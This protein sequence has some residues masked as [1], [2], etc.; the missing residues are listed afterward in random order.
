MSELAQFAWFDSTC[1]FHSGTSSSKLL[2]SLHVPQS[3]FSVSQQ[4]PKSCFHVCRMFL[5]WLII[6]ALALDFLCSVC[7][8]IMKQSP[9]EVDSFSA[10]QITEGKNTGRSISNNIFEKLTAQKN[11]VSSSLTSRT[12]LSTWAL[13][14]F[15]TYY[16]LWLDQVGNCPFFA[17]CYLLINCFNL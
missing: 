17:G 6:S 1:I 5:V 14:S 12:I 8:H 2:L 7:N 9:W 4:A 11:A 15:E 3:A 16:F 13:D 10:S